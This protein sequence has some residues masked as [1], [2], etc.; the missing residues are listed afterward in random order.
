MKLVKLFSLVA[1]ICL[2]LTPAASMAAGKVGV[3]DVRKCLQMTDLGKATYAELKAEVD[4]I[5]EELNSKE[6][7]IEGIRTKLEKGVG[8]LSDSARLK[9]ESDLR[10]KSRSYRDLY[11][12]SQ[13]R[14]RQL[15][16]ER[17]R[18]ILDKMFAVI[19]GFGK[20][21]GYDVIMDMTGG[22]LYSNPAVDLTNPIIKEFNTKH[23]VK[24][25][26]KK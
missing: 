22:V 10:R 16:V 13:A 24:K 19:K 23:P 25:K 1:I 4:R 5:Q 12:E 3:V 21:N 6:R 8:V 7:A 15:E 18:P 20:A 17:T 26:G 14:I 9:L 2:L 11:E